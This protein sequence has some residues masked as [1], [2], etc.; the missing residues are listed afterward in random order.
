MKLENKTDFPKDR[1]FIVHIPDGDLQSLDGV[2]FENFDDLAERCVDL[3]HLIP[4][5]PVA[6]IKAR[7]GEGTDIFSV[8]ITGSKEKGY[9]LSQQIKPKTYATI[10]SITLE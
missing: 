1:R 4:K 10:G 6:A 3:R 5:D 9:L 2:V 8:Y 7:P